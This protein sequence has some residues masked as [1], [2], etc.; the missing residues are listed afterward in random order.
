VRQGITVILQSAQY[1]FVGFWDTDLATP[2]SAIVQF[3]KHIQSNE[4]L[5]AVCG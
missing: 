5:A 4:G 1:K 2:L 3:V